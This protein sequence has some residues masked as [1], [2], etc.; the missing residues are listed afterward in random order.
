MS[1]LPN[2]ST[3]LE[4]LAGW[5][6]AYVATMTRHAG[7][8]FAYGASDCLIVIAD[9]CLA[10]CGR[11][12]V[13]ARLRRYRTMRGAAR[14]MAALGFVDAE[15][16]LAA[17]FPRIAPAVARRGDCG[18]VET[19]VDGKTVKAAVVVM[20]ATVQGKGEAGPVRLPRSALTAAFAIGSI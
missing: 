2:W 3:P 12:P 14:Q 7:A 16:A 11:N 1:K 6:P 15:A 17:I 4:R 18:I 19:T 10:M 13:P 9:L 5:E 20:G 8:P